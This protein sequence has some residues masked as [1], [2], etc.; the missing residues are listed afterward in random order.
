MDKLPLTIGILSW[1]ARATLL[2]TLES[3]KEAGLLDIA[4]QVFVFFQE[5]N[6]EDIDIANEYGLEY[7]GND[8]NLGIAEGYKAMLL[9]ATQPYYL[10]LENDWKIDN[11]IHSPHYVADLIVDGTLFLNAPALHPDKADVVRY[12]SRSWPGNP[13]WTRQFQGHELWRP[14]HLLDSLHWRS[15][16]Q[17]AEFRDKIQAGAYGFYHTTSKY[18]NWTNNPHMVR[19]EWIKSL[20]DKF[21]NGDIER[22]FQGWWEQQ[23]FRVAQ[24]EGLFTHWRL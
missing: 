14:E 23:D 24:G 2:N 10:F 3:Y 16:T 5:I 1:G 15:D 12:R 4:A 21:G 9:N 8:I 6:Q 13:L 18:A 19:T 7:Y 17:M 22:D 20:A 11:G